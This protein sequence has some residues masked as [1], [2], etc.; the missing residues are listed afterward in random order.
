VGR[1]DADSRDT[2][3]RLV[4]ALVAR[5]A[6]R[7]VDLVLDLLVPLR[8]V[9]RAELRRD[10]EELMDSYADA[11]L[12]EVDLAE[13][14]HRIVDAMTR[15]RLKF[16]SDLLLL[17][18]ALVTIESV[19]RNLDPSFR[20]LE[21]AAPMVEEVWLQRH[22][23]GALTERAAEAARDAATL[24]RSLPREVGALLRK[25]RGD[26]LQI[27]FVHRNL[28]HFVLEMDRS[29][30]RLSFAV[31]IAALVIASSLLIGVGSGT[32]LPA[33]GLAG[34]LVAAILGIWL[35]IGILRSGRL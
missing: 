22:L 26:N 28:E 16:P 14:L 13:V 35:V 4:R 33:L 30:N 2:L 7:A 1:L 23:P 24:V 3:L 34:F 5:D 31:I 10:I 15:H 8:E 32:G 12:E 29:S 20:M 27:Q 21:H 25:A 11:A 17:I 6:D 18:K 9:D 19:G